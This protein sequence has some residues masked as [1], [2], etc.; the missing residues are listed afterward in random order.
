[1]LHHEN[2]INALKSYPL[3]NVTFLVKT[4]LFPPA[5]PSGFANILLT[6]EV[7]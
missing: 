3:I 2:L 5:L 4:E 7:G 1:M 6:K